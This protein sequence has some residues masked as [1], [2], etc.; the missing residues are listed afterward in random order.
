VALTISSG[1]T[2]GATLSGCSASL[3]SGVTTF[4]ACQIDKSGASYVLQARDGT[5]SVNTSP[6][7]V[8]AGAATR[9]VVTTEPSGA[10]GGTAF[11]TQPVVTAQDAG[12]NTATSYAGTVTLS[13]ASGGTAG[14]T[15]SGCSASLRNGVTTFSG[16]QIDKVGTGYV[17]QARDGTLSVNASAFNVTAGNATRLVFSTEPGG[18]AKNALLS[19][20]PVVTALD[21]G[22]N[23]ATSYAGTVT[24][25]IGSGTG[26]LSG[27]S[28]SLRSGVTTFSGCKLDR[29]G[30]FTLHASDGTLTGDSSS[31]TVTFGSAAQLL[32][33]TQPVGARAGNVFATQPAITAYDAGGNVVT[34]YSSTITLSIKSGTGA[35]GATLSGCSE[36]HSSGVTTFS[37]CKIDKSGTGYVLHAAASALTVDSNPF[38]MS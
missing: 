3:R 29:T 24:L 17:L 7:D 10:K 1:G 14:A 27:C 12:G 21:A 4:S 35:S 28:G 5:L 2:A 8:S 6:F 22:G 26:T 9:L 16:C 13:I 15:L 34:N 31:F 23:V 37:G 32:F 11:T 20:Q 30:T 18:A 25:T 33:T 38:N 19:P 36:N